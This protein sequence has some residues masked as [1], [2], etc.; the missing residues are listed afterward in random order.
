MGLRM[1]EQMYRELHYRIE[2]EFYP[3]II[4]YISKSEYK[5]IKFQDSIFKILCEYISAFKLCLRVSS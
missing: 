4:K 5:Y 3:A 2:D 1:W